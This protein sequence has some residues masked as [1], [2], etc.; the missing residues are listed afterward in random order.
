MSMGIFKTILEVISAFRKT[1]KQDKPYSSEEKKKLKKLIE[2]LNSL[3]LIV[4]YGPDL[5][6]EFLS[7][8]FN[9]LGEEEDYKQ[10]LDLNLFDRHVCFNSF[11]PNE[12]IRKIFKNPFFSED[13]FKKYT[14]LSE[15]LGEPERIRPKAGWVYIRDSSTEFSLDFD[16]YP[17]KFTTLREFYSKLVELKQAIETR[18][19]IRF[20]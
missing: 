13:I 8:R 17:H 1:I 12:R 6:Y 15:S 4:Q 5:S 18:A 10:Y 3:V 16:Y 20:K 11:F 2:E 14:F 9:S 7:I 19:K